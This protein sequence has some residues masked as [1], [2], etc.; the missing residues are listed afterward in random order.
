[1][2]MDLPK[3][4]LTNIDILKYTKLKKIPHFRGCYMKDNLPKKIRK[5]RETGIINIDNA[6][7]PGTH[8]TAYKKDSH[9][10]VFFDSY[11]SIPPPKQVVEYFK[12]NGKV[13]IFYNYKQIGR[14]HV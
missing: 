13:N 6:D 3:R 8:W 10:I 14:A 1:M 12:S 7:G 9:N 11:G 4:P 5:L 2:M